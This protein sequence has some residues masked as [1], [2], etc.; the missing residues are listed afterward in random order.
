MRDHPWPTRYLQHCRT[1]QTRYPL[2][3]H[4]IQT[5]RMFTRLKPR[6]GRRH[7]RWCKSFGPPRRRRVS[8]RRA[9]SK[10]IRHLPYRLGRLAA[11][12]DQ[13]RPSVCRSCRG[14]AQSVE[15]PTLSR[16]TNSCQGYRKDLLRTSA[17]P[18]YETDLA[19]GAA[20]AS[21]Q[22][23]P[24]CGGVKHVQS[25]SASIVQKWSGGAN[26]SPHWTRRPAQRALSCTSLPVRALPTGRTRWAHS[27][28]ASH[29]C[30]H[31]RRS[32][33][34]SSPAW[35]IGYRHHP[36]RHYHLRRRIHPDCTE[37]L[38]VAAL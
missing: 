3:A 35:R 7:R 33:Q 2:M 16:G 13:S 23:R 20:A 31:R 17:R 8:R 15:T 22:K 5:S 11:V 25:S 21:F 32:Q 14:L 26:S 10:G 24:M 4:L 36:H 37:P 28:L 34:S 38:R 27:R 19:A 29:R 12:S 9:V 6:L 18:V 1:R 30:L